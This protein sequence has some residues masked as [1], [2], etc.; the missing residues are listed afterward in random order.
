ME[1]PVFNPSG[2]VFVP[3]TGSLILYN[4][5]LNITFESSNY[6][7]WKNTTYITLGDEVH[8]F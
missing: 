5:N 8:K 7:I 2:C 4:E 6:N 1:N 3:N